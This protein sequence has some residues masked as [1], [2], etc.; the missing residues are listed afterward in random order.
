MSLPVGSGVFG[1][2]LFASDE[3]QIAITQTACNPLFEKSLKKM[4]LI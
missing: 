2:V 3:Q 1:S 4:K